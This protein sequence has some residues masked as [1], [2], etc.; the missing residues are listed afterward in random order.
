MK[1][2]IPVRG[3]TKVNT[4]IGIG[5][6]I[7]KFVDEN[8]KY[9]SLPCISYHLSTMDV[10]LLSP[11]TYHHLHGDPSIIKGF[12]VKMVLKNHNIFIPIKRQESNPP[13]IRY[14]YVTSAQQK[15]HGP[16]LISGM[17]I[18]S[19]NYLDLFGNLR[20][21]TDNIVTEIEVMLT[22]KFYHFYQV[23]GPCIGSI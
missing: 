20:T 3:V 11:R 16:L 1:F 4:D 9:L 2:D 17:T 13:I 21:D 5:T 14:C 23:C 8:G 6:T 10:R 19:L 15:H 22:N 12:N 18:I 7:H